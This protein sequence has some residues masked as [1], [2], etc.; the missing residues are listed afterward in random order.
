[1]TTTDE[2]TAKVKVTLGGKT[3]VLQPPR[4]KDVD[5]SLLVDLRRMFTRAGLRQP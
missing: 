3:E 5:A 4:G 1:V 2:H